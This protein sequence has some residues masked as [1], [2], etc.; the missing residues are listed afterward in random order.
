MQIYCILLAISRFPFVIFFNTNAYF[1]EY[2]Y[3]YIY[4]TTILNLD[5][6][7]ILHGHP[8]NNNYISSVYS[9]HIDGYDLLAPICLRNTR[10]LMMCS[11]RIL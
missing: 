11:D 9:I 3:V 8:V 5:L 7:H 10:S 6:L 4:L 1:N 2:I